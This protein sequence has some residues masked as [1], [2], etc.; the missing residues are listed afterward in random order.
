[1]SQLETTNPEPQHGAGSQAGVGVF[2]L[3]VNRNYSGIPGVR[4]PGPRSLVLS[5]AKPIIV[6][7]GEWV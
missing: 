6:D 5:P 4:I 3:Q 1:M 7:C 2:S